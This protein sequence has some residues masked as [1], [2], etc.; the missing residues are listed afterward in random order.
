MLNK[1]RDSRGPKLRARTCSRNKYSEK[2]TR[3]NL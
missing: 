3:K 2:K 1:R